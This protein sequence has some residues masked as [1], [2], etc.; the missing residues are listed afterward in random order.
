MGR[1]AFLKDRWS[2]DNAVENPTSERQTSGRLGIWGQ[3]AHVQIL[4]DIYYPLCHEST[5]SDGLVFHSCKVSFNM[6][7][8]QG[9][10][11]HR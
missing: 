2:S 7:I 1:G 11:R 10:I 8:L 3:R 6:L 9:L 4:R 5:T